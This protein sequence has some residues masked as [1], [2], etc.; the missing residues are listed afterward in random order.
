VRIP[1]STPAPSPF[2]EIIMDESELRALALAL[3]ATALIVNGLVFIG[4]V[5]VGSRI[6]RLVRRR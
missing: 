5:A 3:G 6:A 2:S 4:A 1:D